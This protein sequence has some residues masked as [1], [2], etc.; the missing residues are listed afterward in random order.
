[1]EHDRING[2]KCSISNCIYNRDSSE[3]VAGKIDVSS[4]G[5]TNPNCPAQTECKTFKARNC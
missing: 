2:V 3:C 5:C 4:C 1:M